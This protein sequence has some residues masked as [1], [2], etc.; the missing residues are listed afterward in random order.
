MSFVIAAPSGRCDFQGDGGGPAFTLISRDESCEWLGSFDFLTMMTHHYS[1]ASCNS[2]TW[3][4]SPMRDASA[5]LFESFAPLES[6]QAASTLDEQLIRLSTPSLRNTFLRE[7]GKCPASL[8]DPILSARCSDY[9]D[10][11]VERS[12]SPSPLCIEPP[13]AC[14]SKR[15]RIKPLFQVVVIKRTLRSTPNHQARCRARSL[16]RPTCDAPPSLVTS[17]TA[18]PPTPIPY[19]QPTASSLLDRP[20]SCAT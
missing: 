12:C 16:A 2:S 18:S 3:I 17:T 10:G 9:K 4:D 20:A 11:A 14:A 1:H 6:A 15:S 5:C 7:S 19:W 13:A 8:Q